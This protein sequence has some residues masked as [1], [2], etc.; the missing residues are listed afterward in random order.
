MP[1]TRPTCLLVLSLTLVAC[2]GDTKSAGAAEG[3]PAK[4]TPEDCQKAYEHLADLKLAKSPTDFTKEELLAIDK[5]NIETC[6]KSGTKAEV[7]CLMAIQA[8]DMMAIADCHGVK[9]K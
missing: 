4:A 3:A 2:G 8:H 5:G 6:Q 1:R 7:E 9:K